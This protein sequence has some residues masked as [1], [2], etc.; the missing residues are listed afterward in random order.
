MFVTICLFILFAYVLY[1]AGYV[2]GR[3]T[4]RDKHKKEEK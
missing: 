1:T 2:M 4:E 3:K